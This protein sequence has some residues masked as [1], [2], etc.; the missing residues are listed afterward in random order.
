MVILSINRSFFWTMGGIGGVPSVYL[1]IEGFINAGHHVHY[2]YSDDTNRRKFEIIDGINVYRFC[3]PFGLTN[4]SRVSKYFAVS[5]TQKIWRFVLGNLRWLLFNIVGVLEGLN[6]SRRVKPDIIYANTEQTALIGY[7]LS[8][9]TRR[10][11][12]V[13][14]Y[15]LG[16]LYWRLDS[17]FSKIKNFRTLL[18][19][20]V[21]ADRFIIIEDGNNSHLVAK[22]MGVPDSKIV[23]WRNGIDFN[24]YN[25][26]PGLRFE[27]RKK[28]GI[29]QD[30]PIILAVTRLDELKRVDRL[31]QYLPQL[32]KEEHDSVC[33][34][35]GDG[36]KRHELEKMCRD[37]A[38][39]KRVIFTGYVS[40]DQ[41]VDIQ[42]AADIFVAL[43]DYSNC[44]NSL[45][46]S[47]ACAKCVVTLNNNDYTKQIIKSQD[48]GVLILPEELYK[49]PEILF[50]LLKDAEK[51]KRMGLRARDTV[52]RF[53]GTWDARIAKEIKLLESI[54]KNEI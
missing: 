19:F 54:I 3:L 39:D 13:R 23:N 17:V 30:K 4:E 8:I 35:V 41:V 21:P 7:F 40:R 24:I 49:L 11:F 45:W 47:M 16:G 34:I 20:K 15:G 46:E 29:Q 9:F 25:P 38:I 44:G 26:D 51:R 48:N 43:S 5:V 1:P 6:I 42:N 36:P 12:I 18:A 22:K 50:D 53:M 37:S 28:L 2:L 10:P 33:V 52:Q 14:I 32:F 31:V 27:V